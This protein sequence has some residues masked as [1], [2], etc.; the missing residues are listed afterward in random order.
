[1]GN[2]DIIAAK[3]T[4]VGDSWQARVIPFSAT[5]IGSPV[6]SDTMTIN[7]SMS[8]YVK[9]VL[10]EPI[11]GVVVTADNGGS[12]TITSADGFYQVAVPYEWTG[13]ISAEKTDYSMVSPVFALPAVADQ[14]GDYIAQL[15]ADIDNS[16]RV[17]LADLEMLCNNWLA[18]A[19][20]NAGDINGSGFVDLMD[21]AKIAEYWIE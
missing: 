10:A 13:L 6:L 2:N 17:S 18:Y 4:A 1:T 14:T 7:A 20:A 3:E 8:G 11:A 21:M 12:E 16:G 5:H 9:N 19:P 15:I